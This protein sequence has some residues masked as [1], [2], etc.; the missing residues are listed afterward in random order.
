V[1]GAI[2]YAQKLKKPER[3]LCIIADSGNRYTSKIYNDQWMQ[4]KGF[5]VA[6]AHPIKNQ[7]QD[8]LKSKGVQL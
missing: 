4:S 6:A 2:R 8:I 3:I 5:S 1:V 7:I